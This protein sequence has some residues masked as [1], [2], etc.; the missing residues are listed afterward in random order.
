MHDLDSSVIESFALNEFEKALVDMTPIPNVIQAISFRSQNQTADIHRKSILNAFNKLENSTVK[1]KCF[2][3]AHILSPHPPFVFG[4][5]GEEVLHYE[6]LSGW[7]GSHILDRGL[8]REGYIS[9]YKDQAKFTTDRILEV[10][11]K[12]ISETSPPPVII[13]QSDHGPGSMLDWEDYTKSDLDERYGIINAYL[14]P[15]RNY[16]G[17]YQEVTPVNSFRL[18]FNSLFGTSFPMLEDSSYFSTY[19]HPYLFV[20]ITELLS[21]VVR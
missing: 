4:P 19:S 7:D 17:F 12:I 16:D 20:D 21:D 1:T 10:I 18:V 11:E 8:T 14:L 5:N 13:L 2:I 15:D 9:H 6:S 3:F